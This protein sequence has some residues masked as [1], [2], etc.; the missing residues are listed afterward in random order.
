MTRYA[1]SVWTRVGGE[2]AGER[3]ERYEIVGKGGSE[4]KQERKQERKKRNDESLMISGGEE[5]G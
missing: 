1:F 5:R 2:R 3:G 4:R